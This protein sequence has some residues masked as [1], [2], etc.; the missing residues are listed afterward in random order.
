MTPEGGVIPLKKP[1]PNKVNTYIIIV[2]NEARP[3]TSTIF[4]V[5]K[6]PA[7]A[8]VPLCPAGFV[9]L[10]PGGLY[11]TQAWPAQ[12]RN[13]HMSWADGRRPGTKVL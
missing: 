13:R 6:I 8:F 12:T 3:L 10:R 7:G 11:R 5:K 9:P 2:D 4:N 1:W